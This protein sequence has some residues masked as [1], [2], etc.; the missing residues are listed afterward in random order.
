[1]Q[2]NVSAAQNPTVVSATLTQQHPV[3]RYVSVISSKTAGNSFI[4]IL[5]FYLIAILSSRGNNNY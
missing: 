4:F 3:A 5:L 2:Q 1:M